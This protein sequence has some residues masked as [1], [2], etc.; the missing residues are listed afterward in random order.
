MNVE[1]DFS[2]FSS[3]TKAFARVFGGWAAR[4]DLAE[5]DVIDLSPTALTLKVVS[6]ATMTPG[7]IVIGLSDVVFNSLAEAEELAQKL[8]TDCGLF[9]DVFD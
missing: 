2:I 4:P 7:G 8:E 1:I 6:I 9:V 3:P 5:G